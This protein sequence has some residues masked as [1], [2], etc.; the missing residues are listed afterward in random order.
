[1]VFSLSSYAVEYQCEGKHIDGKKEY[2]IKLKVRN[3]KITIKTYHDGIEVQNCNGK[4]VFDIKSEGSIV[5]SH[6]V[7]W[8][9]MCNEYQKSNLVFHQKGDLKLYEDQSKYDDA[10]F[11]K[12]KEAI[13]CKSSGLK[14]KFIADIRKKM[15]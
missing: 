8:E 2:R 10:F 11:L 7:Y 12:N 14:S 15:N 4:T 3:S 1:M 13:K 6:H 9:V 5:R